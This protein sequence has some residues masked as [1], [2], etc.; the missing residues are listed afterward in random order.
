[1]QF[2]LDG[3][4]LGK[5]IDGFHADTVIGTGPIDLGEVDLKKGTATL[6]VEVVGTNPK[7]DGMRTMW[8]LD[9]IVLKSVAP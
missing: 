7:S 5:P 6:R 8:G 3:K 9:C 1:M 2:H 4:L